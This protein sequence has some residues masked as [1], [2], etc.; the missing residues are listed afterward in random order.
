MAIPAS[1]L[2]DSARCTF[3]PQPEPRKNEDLVHARVFVVV[4]VDVGNALVGVVVVVIGAVGA[5]AHALVIGDF[6]FSSAFSARKTGKR[7]R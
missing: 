5:D 1:R 7:V 4:V 3:Y 6:S 2:G